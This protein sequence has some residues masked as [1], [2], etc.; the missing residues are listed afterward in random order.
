MA[1]LLDRVLAAAFRAEARSSSDSDVK[2][3]AEKELPTLEDHLKAAQN[4]NRQVATSGHAAARTRGR[5]NV[6]APLTL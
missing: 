5:K 1:D 2:L 3:F 4:A 6:S